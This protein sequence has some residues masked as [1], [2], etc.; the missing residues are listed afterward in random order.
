MTLKPGCIREIG[1]TLYES[2]ISYSIIESS[3]LTMFIMEGLLTRLKDLISSFSGQREKTPHPCGY[4]YNTGVL[5]FLKSL[6]VYRK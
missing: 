3:L 1:L 2:N 5:H 4:E 6:S